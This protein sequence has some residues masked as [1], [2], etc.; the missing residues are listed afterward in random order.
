VALDDDPRE[1]AGVVDIQ[2]EQLAEPVD[3]VAHR[4]RVQ[5]QLCGGVG[6]VP[7]RERIAAQGGPVL[8]VV[9]A[10]ELLDLTED[11]EPV[12]VV[13]EPSTAHALQEIAASVGGQT[14][15]LIDG[16]IRRGS[17]ILTLTALGASACLVGRPAV[18][19]AV[20]A[21]QPGV[22]AILRTLAEEAA[23]ALA[24]TGA[25]RLDDLN[26]DMVAGPTA[27]RSAGQRSHPPARDVLVDAAGRS[28]FC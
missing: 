22:S 5:V 23:T 9:R 16:G 27:C 6:V 8:G 13:A 19:G 24:F 10:V 2:A 15:I 4:V 17:D 7:L 11:R 1:G 20:T 14:E 3:P 28:W 18:Y 12:R 21:G 25:T 26:P